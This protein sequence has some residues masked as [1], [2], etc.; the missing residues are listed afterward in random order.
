[1]N[2]FDVRGG[3]DEIVSEIVSNRDYQPVQ[4]MLR[5]LL[6]P[7]NRGGWSE[8]ARTNISEQSLLRIYVAA[9]SNDYHLITQV[10]ESKGL[11]APSLAILGDLL[12]VKGLIS[13]SHVYSSKS[14][15]FKNHH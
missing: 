14:P 3:L 6:H 2:Q 7:R 11:Y 12:E 9:L 1:M 15:T 10:G 4:R 13:S 5:L 8:F